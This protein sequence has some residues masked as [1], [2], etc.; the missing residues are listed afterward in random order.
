M[1]PRLSSHA[2]AILEA[3]AARRARSVAD[4][5]PLLRRQR[6]RPVAWAIAPL[7]PAV[8]GLCLPLPEA[9]LI[10]CAPLEPET[11]ALSALHE[12]AHLWLG[13]APPGGAGPALA[14]SQLPLGEA[15]R[16]AEALAARLLHL[17]AG[18]AYRR[19]LRR[20]GALLPVL[21]T[22]ITTVAPL[23]QRIPLDDDLAAIG[24]LHGIMDA[25]RIILSHAPR[26][27]ADAG[28]EAAMLLEAYR[29][30]RRVYG[31]G[32]HPPP[33]ADPERLLAVAAHL[34][35]ATGVPGGYGDSAR[36]VRSAWMTA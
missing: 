22:V 1:G 27:P 15:E 23:A 32:P 11:I 10:V 33:R 24:C 4:L 36:P 17:I 19:V 28:D 5:L 9:D 3:C 7:P 8:T 13:H 14:R 18:P 34:W 16:E 21:H 25:R 30:G 31:C 6:G 26:A 29:A 35:R 12:L 2:A 20:G